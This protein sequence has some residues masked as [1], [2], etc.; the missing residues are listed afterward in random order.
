[1]TKDEVFAVVMEA[2]VMTETDKQRASEMVERLSERFPAFAAHRKVAD[3][4][5]IYGL[6]LAR[7]PVPEPRKRGK[8]QNVSITGEVEQQ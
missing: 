7:V 8:K 4:C 6:A 3:A 1:M 2:Q 5:A